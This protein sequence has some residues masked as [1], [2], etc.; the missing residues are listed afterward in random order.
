MKHCLLPALFTLL[1][2]TVA[3]A[4]TGVVTGVLERPTEIT[5]LVAVDRTDDRKDGIGSLKKGYPGRVDT[6]TGRFTIQGLPLGKKYDLILE[7]GPVRLEGVALND[8][9][10]SDFEEEQPLSAAD[11]KKIEKIARALN[12]FEDQVEVMAIAG[13]IQHATVLLNKLRTK[14]FFESKPGEVIW[15]LELWRFEKPEENWIKSQELLALVYY[16]ERL[17]RSDFEKKMLTLDPA[18]GGIAV[19]EKAPTVDLGKIALPDRKPGIHLRKE[20]IKE[21]SSSP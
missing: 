17:Q 19:T 7:A 21:V 1:G 9:P 16:R 3:H 2:A 13:N 15:R 11:R 18:L 10:P 8:V 4:Q 20:N 6:N 14:P 12:V 5:E